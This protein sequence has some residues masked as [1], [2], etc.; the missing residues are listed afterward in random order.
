MKVVNREVLV[1]QGAQENDAAV[2]DVWIRLSHAAK[3][4]WVK[5]DG[6]LG[7]KMGMNDYTVMQVKGNEFMDKIKDHII[8]S[9]SCRTDFI[10]VLSS[11]E[12]MDLKKIV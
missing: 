2:K 9:E 6:Y 7:A 3:E 4:L 8:E 1:K 11:D 5:N 10:R 12:A